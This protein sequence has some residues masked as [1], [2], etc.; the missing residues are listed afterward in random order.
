MKQL[1]YLT[2]KS[3][4]N[5]K[6]AFIL[7]VISIAIS[8]VL[9]LG[10]NK[11]V[12]SSK[13]HFINTIHETDVIVAASNGSIDILLNLIFHISDPL[14]EMDYT[15]YEDISIMEEV[16]WAVP[17]SL[18]DSFKSFDVVST[19]AEY[20]KHYKYSSGKHLEFLKGSGFNG[21]YDVV[22]GANVAKKLA[23]KV[24]D[25]LH[26]SHGK[27]KHTHKNREFKV[28]GILKKSMTPNDDSVFM[29]LKADEAIHIEWKSG[30][31]IDM[32]ISSE[33][34]SHMN[35]KP[36]HIS[37]ALIG[38]KERSSILSFVDKINNNGKN[39]KAVIPAKALTKL[40]KLVKNLQD[41]LMLISIAVFVAAVF[42][43]LSTMYSTLNDRRREIAIFR[44]LGASSKVVFFLFAIE[45]FFIVV[46]GVLLGIF[47]LDV[48]LLITRLYIPLDFSYGVDLYQFLMLFIM[49]VV[50]LFASL[51]PA[52]KSY[53]SSIQDG[54]MVKI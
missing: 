19:N 1:F 38:L 36:K 30:H 42:T 24:S 46:G 37:G 7:S 39:L 25:T 50:A 16:S 21:F 41:I 43:M 9:L 28:V 3:I 47:V 23:M 35:V 53:K 12:K 14:A 17:I 11:I 32:H 51:L 52:V 34:L 20:F 45:S 44:S 54:L 26:L 5:R 31:F 8:V 4:L 22:L 6:I 29:Q 48:V 33:S 27:H 10:V 13:E 49:I 15:T 2:Y 18:G 40:Y